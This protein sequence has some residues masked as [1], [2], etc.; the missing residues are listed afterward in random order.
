MR[1]RTETRTRHV[2]HTIDGHT[3]L[4]PEQYTVQTPVAP[5]DW[6]HIALTAVTASTAALV[7]VSIVWSTA[8]IG[9]LLA[10]ATAAPVAYGA[11]G[12]FDIVWVNCML[13]EWL[14]RYDPARARIPRVAG[15]I[16]LAIAMAAVCAH[17]RL[18]DSLTVGVAGAAISAL[19][20]GAWTLALRAHA[21]PLDARSQAWLINRQARIGARLALDSQMRQ[22]H[23]LEARAAIGPSP[24]ADPAQ[25]GQATDD[26]DDEEQPP[27]TGPMTIADAVRTALDSGITAPDRVLA[28]AR[29]VAD[30]NAK[31]ETVDRY[32]RRAKLAG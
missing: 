19:A 28:Y 1:Y 18:E 27:A 13:L 31:A 10:R 17:G 8:S 12:A 32:I 15:H 26:P 11:A 23:R 30:A 24:D 14:A 25:S 16:A 5:R 29:K 21:R 6:D 4:V 9:D 3:E 2:L 22:L 20:K 7:L